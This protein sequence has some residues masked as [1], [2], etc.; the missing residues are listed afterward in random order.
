[1]AKSDGLKICSLNCQGLGNFKKRKDVFQYLRKSNC[2]IFCLQDT[3]FDKSLEKLVANEWGFRV[4]FSSHDSRSRGVAI[5]FNNNF[6]FKIHKTITDCSGNFIIIEIEVLTKR[7]LLV[8]IYGPN[9]DN[10]NFYEKI[11]N[12]VKELNNVN[13]IMVGDWNLLIN[14][15]LDG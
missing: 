4:Y 2:S 13:I 12:Y 1:M 6:E 9:K 5:L 15:E 7:F 3:H 8:N 14:P 10:P 11:S